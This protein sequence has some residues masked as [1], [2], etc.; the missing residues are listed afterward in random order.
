MFL[1]VTTVAD[2]LNPCHIFALSIHPSLR[3]LFSVSSDLLTDSEWAEPR[4][5]QESLCCLCLI[6]WGH[7]CLLWSLPW[8]VWE[9]RDEAD[10]DGGVVEEEQRERELR[11]LEWRERGQERKARGDEKIPLEIRAC[12]TNTKTESDILD[13]THKLRAGICYYTSHPL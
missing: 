13:Q 12:R 10:R 3:H 4:A 1:C 7:S 11:K 8:L 2:M 9:K 5:S 6:Q